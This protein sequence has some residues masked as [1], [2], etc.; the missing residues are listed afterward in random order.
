MITSS[1]RSL[2]YSRKSVRPS[3]DPWGTPASTGYS[4]EDVPS[5]TTGNR[6]LLR[7]EEIR[8][9]IWPERLK[10]MK[11][12]SMP[13][14]VKSLW[15]IKFH[16][17]NSPRSI[18]SPSNSIRYNCEKIC[19]WS[20][21][22]KTILEMR[23]KVTFFQVINNPITYKFLQQTIIYNNH[24]FKEFTNHRKKTNM[25]VVFSCRP[26]PNILKYGD[27]W[28]NLPTIWKTRLLEKLIEEL[29]ENSDSQFFRLA[30]VQS[31]PDAFDKPRFIMTFLTT[32]QV[33]E[34]LCSFK[35]VL[36]AKTGKEILESS[37]LEFLEKFPADNYAL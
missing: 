37:R 1:G 19:S 15:Y 10:F 13:N 9:N 24:I 21:R 5:W 17:L 28:W 12:I 26:F 23:K 2:I 11:K 20:R 34:I 3:M 35:L 30:T 25:A 36:A 29:W 7:K 4:R 18:K 27:H 14:T 31:G 33:T 6:L 16:S 22:P 32:F 8:S